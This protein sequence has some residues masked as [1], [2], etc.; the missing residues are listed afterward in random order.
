MSRLK[1]FALLHCLFPIGDKVMGTCVM[2]WYKRISQMNQWSRQEIREWQNEELR[3]FVNHAY[4]HTVY[5]RKLFDNLGLT[6]DDIQCK[7]DLV[8]IPVMTK[9][10]VNENYEALIP[11]NLNQFKY[12]LSRSGG[13]TGV[14][15]QY[16][17][18]ENVWGYVTAARIYYWKKTDYH[19]GDAFIAL[20][21]ASLFSQKPTFARRLYDRMRNEHPLN[22]VN[23]TDGICAEYCEYIKAH[24][25]HFIYGY[26]AAI[27]MFAVYVKE[28]Q[29]D[30]G[31]IKRVF[32]TSENLT[33]KY[34]EVIEDA[35]HCKVMDC[36]GAR[37]AGITAYEVAP[38]A[39][40]IGYNTL[41][42]ID[43][44][45]A[46]N[47]GSVISTNF[48]N[49]S[50]PLLR[51]QFGDEAELYSENDVNDYN[52]Q[53]FKGLLGRSSHVLR[54]ENNHKLTAT[55]IS[56]IM[57]EFDIVAF[58][59]RKTGENKVLLRIQAIP[60]KYSEQQESLI[61]KTLKKYL[62][63]DCELTIEKVSEFEP[64]KNGKRTYFMV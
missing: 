26:A 3:K 33:D 7:E 29:V 42:E 31:G 4:K 14:P 63:D 16:Y 20:G 25:I 2:K 53:R 64:N 17:C 37:D 36:Y 51:Y 38:H 56:M 58:D 57:K 60:D 30:V 45:I 13:T 43:N 34:R 41:V 46:D 28:H 15:V 59:I 62:G 22:C 1:E 40:N 9:E 48:L 18:D 50:F 39:Y 10:I 27:Y 11:D 5:Y 24:H 54:L 32:T 47:V 21:S 49:F 44:E 19:Y 8:K 61:I 35:F 52:G 23:L 55:G 12:R 6:P